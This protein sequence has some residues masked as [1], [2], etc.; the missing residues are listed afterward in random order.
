M[1]RI[2]LRL[3]LLMLA[4]SAMAWPGAAGA[5]SEHK[6]SPPARSR[7]STTSD[8]VTSAASPVSV[9][10]VIQ[11][12]S[13]LDGQQFREVVQ[14][15]LDSTSTARVVFVAPAFAALSAPPAAQVVALLAGS[16]GPDSAAIVV[17]P[18]SAQPK[19]AFN[20]T[21]LLY[22]RIGERLLAGSVVLN[23][24]APAAVWSE[25][26]TI[27]PDCASLCTLLAH[28]SAVPESV[29]V[30]SG[31]HRVTSAAQLSDQLGTAGTGGITW[32]EVMPP[33][34]ATFARV[35]STGGRTGKVT[36]RPPL[37]PKKP[38][39]GFPAP[40]V[41]ALILA[42]CLGTLVLLRLRT[43]AARRRRRRPVEQRRRRG[44]SGGAPAGRRPD[45]LVPTR[46]GPVMQFRVAA[47]AFVRSALAPEGY[48]EIDDCLVRARWAD[49]APPPYPGQ[50]VT[51]RFAGD[52]LEATS[53][54][55]PRKEPR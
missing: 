12:P 19:G 15:A 39:G 38:T 36:P 24:G 28:G 23:P 17:T 6:Q 40:L 55:R 18:T 49:R 16:T 1:R 50:M 37:R 44:G 54:A 53:P 9:L 51:T 32:E 41:V 11:L 13:R 33:V 27:E 20:A 25:L 34:P 21:A 42:V 48:I 4:L 52:V 35:F 10:R 26:E 46:P 22:A 45:G 30:R 47:D 7:T 5:A 43:R 14:M 3:L 8:L 31:A 29:L 2:R